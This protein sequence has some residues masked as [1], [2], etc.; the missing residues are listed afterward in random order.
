MKF[1]NN[2]I[3]IMDSLKNYQDVGNV[4]PKVNQIITS[5]YGEDCRCVA[6]VGAEDVKCNILIGNADMY[7]FA[8]SDS[9]SKKFRQVRNNMADDDYILDI[10]SDILHG[11]QLD[12]T[13]KYVILMPWDNMSSTCMP[14]AM[15]C[16]KDKMNKYLRKGE[17]VGG[18]VPKTGDMSPYNLFLDALRGLNEAEIVC[19]YPNS[20]NIAKDSV[21][22]NAALE[23]AKCKHKVLMFV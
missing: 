19:C 7:V 5:C 10:E 20:G 21:L 23:V 14:T 22:Y 3:L 9:P 12:K 17:C 13:N 11:V 6:V 4:K 16:A 18:A 1:P 15:Q 2:Y 8:Y